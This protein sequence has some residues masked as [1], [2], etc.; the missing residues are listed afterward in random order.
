MSMSTS[1]FDPASLKEGK[2]A[3]KPQGTELHSP[4]SSLWT[5]A[6]TLSKDPVTFLP[7]KHHPSAELQVGK[8]FVGE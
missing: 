4:N 5:I 3:P 2:I 8:K 6:V 7:Q 1:W